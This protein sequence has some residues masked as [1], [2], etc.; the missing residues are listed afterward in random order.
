MKNSLRLPTLA[1]AIAGLSLVSGT[2]QAQVFFGGT[3]GRSSTD[4]YE[5]G[6]TDSN[7]HQDDSDT[8]WSLFVG[9]Q[10]NPYFATTIAYT[11]LG[12][13]QASGTIDGGEGGGGSIGYTDKISA[14]AMDV[15][16]IGILPFSTFAS[17]DSFIGRFSL[18]AEVG[19]SLWDQDVNC[20]ACD[21]GSDFKGGDTGS[22]VL[23]GGGLSMR[24]TEGLR[25][26]ARYASY[27]DIGNRD[28]HDT[29]HEQDWDFWGIGATWSIR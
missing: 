5:F 1:A 25:L 20:V 4:D 13:L 22:S 6:T 3:A 29:G 9:Y 27:P 24:V 16:A 8:A 17:E 18:F 14:T 11:D 28:P 21:G 15:S 2:S 19:L 7:R 26:H 12:S 23:L 10:W